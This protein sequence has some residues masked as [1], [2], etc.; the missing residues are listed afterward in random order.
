MTFK[1]RIARKQE[2]IN[3]I[4]DF[5]LCSLQLLILGMGVAIGG[6]IAVCVLAVL[7]AEI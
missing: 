7:C 3:K 4:E 5:I 1:E 2:T 6:S